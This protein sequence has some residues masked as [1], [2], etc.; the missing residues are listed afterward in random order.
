MTIAPQR[1]RNSLTKPESRS[2]R[3][4]TLLGCLILLVWLALAQ[5]LPPNVVPATATATQ[6]SADRAMR[7]LEIIASQ[8]RPMG[9]PGHT[10]ARAYLIGQI[11]ALG[12]QP[13]VQTTTVVQRWQ[14]STRF[15]VGRVQN[16]L[17]RLPG[18]A[19]TGAI[20]LDGHYD[21]GS[22]TNG[23]A[24]CGSCV[25]TLLETLRALR[26]SPPLQNDV[27]FVFADGEENSD[28][29][30]RAFVTQ[31]P[32]AKDVK[33]AL[34]FEATGNRGASV[35]YSANR[36]N[37]P[38]MAGF[39]HAAPFPL[40]SSFA[41]DFVRLFPQMRGGCDLEEYM[42]QQ[43]PGLGFAV[44]SN[45]VGYHTRLD[46]VQQIDRRSIQHHG[47]YALE[48]TRYFGNQ[49]LNTL[50]SEQGAV[51]F[52]VLPNVMVYY[53]MS[54]VLPLAVAVGLLFLVVVSLGIRRG[55]LTLKGM[56]IG[57]IAFA[58][59]AIGSVVLAAL[60]WWGIRSLNLNLQVF[61]VG[62]YQTP[63]YFL[64]LVCFTMTLMVLFNI[65]LSRKV[66]LSDRMAGV[67]L[68]WT[69]LM[70]L[71]SAAMPGAS[72]L[73]TLP[74]LVNLLL[75]GWM[76]IDRGFQSG[77]WAHITALILAALPGI[78]L[79]IPA[80]LYPN[81]AW[82]MRFEAFTNLPFLA[83]AL[84]FM[85][86]LMGL[87]MPQIDLLTGVGDRT[88][89]HDSHRTRRWYLPGALALLSVL[90]L[91]I[92][93]A[94][95]G[96][97]ANQPRPNHIAYELNA[98]TGQATWVSTDA[99]LDSWT[100]QFFPQN[101]ARVDH[102]SFP[103]ERSQV[104]TAPAPTGS[105]APPDVRLIRNISNGNSRELQLQV[106]SP[107]QAI[108]AQ[109]HIKAGGEITAATVNGQVMDLRFL[110]PEQRDRLTFSYY[111]LPTEG[112]D[113]AL[114]IQSPRSLRLIVQDLSYGL[115]TMPGTAIVPRPADRMP[116]PADL[117]PTLVTK[118]FDI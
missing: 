18:T 92:A 28:L 52:N 111:N 41:S 112:I 86:L 49:D 29:G 66:S 19:S 35:L 39:A 118:T 1:P 27:I 105:I 80:M 22:N 109:L 72:Y 38:M 89:H 83:F 51:Y 50:Q 30:A 55:Q 2:V 98:D 37:L 84:V 103:G 113:L 23:A 65:G 90:I 76:I 43:I 102:E 13:E 99:Q 53:P 20:A 24:D 12:L 10:A 54:W 114:T 115:P 26:A 91:G 78:F 63:L 100:A 93:T 15:E 40:A 62:H 104:F 33:L 8:P 110:P 87:L 74:L 36:N 44:A 9:S 68:V 34:N 56:G 116:A 117:D 25:V 4:F 82:M 88:I 7:S 46:N 21:S 97:S 42:D 101:A 48:L 11:E 94:T 69:V 81:L 60:L 79:V 108:N 95:S 107:R 85:A 6:F 45:T 64:G 77:S 59:S 31:H 58:A 47:S 32:W 70:V 57:A 16:V 71:S 61:M 14:G 106:R 67:F 3:L 17:V 75:L 5:L 96:F 73:F